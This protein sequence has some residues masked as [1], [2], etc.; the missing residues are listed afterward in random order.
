MIAGNGE[1]LADTNLLIYC[2]D[3][4]EPV[5]QEQAM[6][7]LRTMIADGRLTVSTQVLGEF[8]HIATRKLRAPLSNDAAW[9]R[10]E[11][12]LSVCRVLDVTPAVIRE[13]IRGVRE[14]RM[15]YWDAQIW[16]VARINSIPVVLSE[17][18]SHNSAIGGV[19]FVNPF[20]R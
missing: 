14:H 5:K 18:F 7:I 19:R 1:C 3:R 10:V 6:E 16:A 4:S 11:H 13:A 17:D 9:E 15:S 12:Y 2:Y 20:R 8:Y